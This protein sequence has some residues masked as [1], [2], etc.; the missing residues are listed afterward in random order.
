MIAA[1]QSNVRNR[2]IRS[3]MNVRLPRTVKEL[4]TLVDKCAHMEEGRKLPGEEDCID[5]D[6][7][8]DDESTSQNKAKKRSKKR[9]DKAMLTVEG[10]GT[11][12]TGK[13]AKTEA[14][15]KEVATCV[16][17]LEDATTE[18][19]GKGDGPYWKIHRTKGHDL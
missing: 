15:G 11:P 14:P 18:K 3:K 17:F 5:V 6:S 16:D 10:S 4:Y 9:R 13:I 2:Q 1:F 12:S 19:V 8:D 7:K